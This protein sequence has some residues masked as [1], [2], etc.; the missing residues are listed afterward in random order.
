M[1]NKLAAAVIAV[2][3]IAGP[4]LA[5]GNAAVPASTSQPAAKA[6]TAKIASKTT[7]KMSV[8]HVKKTHKHAG[9]IAKHRK[10]FAHVKHVKGKHVTQVKHM[11]R[12]AKSVTNG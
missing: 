10:H 9:K 6:D 12:P 3:L 2:S 8:T 5:Q 7:T 4:A 1:F 11:K